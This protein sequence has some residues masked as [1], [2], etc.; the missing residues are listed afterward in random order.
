MKVHPFSISI[1]GSDDTGLQKMNPITVR[2]YDVDRNK[3]VTRFLDMCTS[4][5]ATD[6]GIYRAL[7]SKLLHSL[8]CANPWSMCAFIGVD[9]TSVNIG[10]RDFSDD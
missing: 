5:T 2:I 8:G 7:D 9:N 6:E 1:D 3:L 10:I 4:T